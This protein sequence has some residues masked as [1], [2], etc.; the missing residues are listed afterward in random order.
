MLA[1]AVAVVILILQQRLFH[2][3]AHKEPLVLRSRLRPQTKAAVVV[4]V[5]VPLLLV[6]MVVQ[7]LLLFHT[8]EHKSQLAV[9]YQHLVETPSIHSQHL[10][11]SYLKGINLNG[12]FCKSR[13]R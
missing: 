1:V 3:V 9:M 11:H 7:V 13:P 2:L 6:V 12:K 5:M 10:A 4:E 8:Q